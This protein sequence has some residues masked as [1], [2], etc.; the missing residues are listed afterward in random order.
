MENIFPK[1]PEKCARQNEGAAAPRF[2][3]EH[4]ILPPQLE[5][6]TA[7]PK[8]RGSGRKLTLTLAA[9]PLAMA[10]PHE[11][12]P[13]EMRPLSWATQEPRGWL[14]MKILLAQGRSGRWTTFRVRAFQNTSTGFGRCWLSPSGCSPLWLGSPC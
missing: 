4:N 2:A 14:C 12:S 10:A 3:E 1:E 5:L 7:G 9:D 8:S 6:P 11:P 13:G